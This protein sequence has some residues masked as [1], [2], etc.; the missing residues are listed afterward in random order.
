MSKRFMLASFLPAAALFLSAGCS[1]E[2]TVA[3]GGAPDAAAA[4]DGGSA[5]GGGTEV[6]SRA[7][8]ILDPA[9]R[10]LPVRVEI[11]NMAI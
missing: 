5:D 10:E 9:K 6:T 1:P 2:K 4:D 11:R 3:D 7:M 8:F